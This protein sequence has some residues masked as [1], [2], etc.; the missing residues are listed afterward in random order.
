[1]KTLNINLIA[2][3]ILAVAVGLMVFLFAESRNDPS[4]RIAALVSG[5][6]LVSALAAIASTILTGK[7]VTKPRDPAEMPP[8]TTTTDTSTVNVGP[9]LPVPPAQPK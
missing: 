8:N 9:T 5:T 2:L 6:G 1:V 7:D 4:L 3:I